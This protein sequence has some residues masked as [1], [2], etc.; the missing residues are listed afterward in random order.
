MQ[1]EAKRKLRRSKRSFHKLAKVS[2]PM[3]AIKGSKPPTETKEFNFKTTNGRKSRNNSSRSCGV[4]DVHPSNF[5]NSLRSLDVADNITMV[6]NCIDNDM[7]VTA[8]LSGIWCLLP[9]CPHYVMG[10]L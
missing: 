8:D 5:A 4:R 6:S 10:V 9:L 1:R 7:V 2:G 3:R